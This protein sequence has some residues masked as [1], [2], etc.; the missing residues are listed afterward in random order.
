MA[1]RKRLPKGV[2]GYA[3]FHE[4]N[5]LLCMASGYFGARGEPGAIADHH[6]AGGNQLQL[7]TG[8]ITPDDVAAAM[9]SARYGGVVL[10]EVSTDAL[11]N[12]PSHVTPSGL[13]LERRVPLCFARRACFPSE[14]SRSDFLAKL[15]GYG[16]IRGDVLRLEDDADLFPKSVPQLALNENTSTPAPRPPVAANPMDKI[17]GAVAG[18]LAALRASP[19]LQ[20]ASV[21]RAILGSEHPARSAA[22]LVSLAANTWDVSLE[23]TGQELLIF[24]A[25][26]LL[27]EE[28]P[29]SGISPRDFLRRF[30]DD[31]AKDSASREVASK[32]A[33]RADDIIAA[34][35]EIASDGLADASGKIGA[36]ALLLFLLNPDI[37]RLADAPKRIEGLGPKVHAVASALCGAY[38]GFASMSAKVKAPDQ[39]SYLGTSLLAF[40]LLEALPPELE[41]A[42][43]WNDNGTGSA[44]L[45]IASFALVR[46]PVS[47]PETLL[48]A[49]GLCKQM[50][51]KPKLDPA[52]GII[53]LSPGSLGLEHAS[54]RMSLTYSFPR[55]PA[56][57]LFAQLP[58]WNNAV[59][60]EI[61]AAFSNTLVLAKPGPNKKAPVEVSVQC[62]ASALSTASLLEAIEALAECLRKY[63]SRPERRKAQSN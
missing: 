8:P 50:P 58:V 19:T 56:V 7:H 15:G 35:S 29:G 54:L 34:R 39:S 4:T 30:V 53:S 24:H 61:S 28:P 60:N 43:T 26:K 23:R 5:L 40:R 17:A 42:T 55:N 18:L 47:L 10:V 57:E 12:N 49:Y 31:F 63:G 52:S 33:K 2:L 41:I 45:Q 6:N 59:A 51:L 37:D 14:Q 22:E 32:F 1:K 27:A 62:T 13:R 3:L 21:G 48:K 36:R 11:P 44:S 16:D 46:Q 9:G 20:A 38:L 25:A